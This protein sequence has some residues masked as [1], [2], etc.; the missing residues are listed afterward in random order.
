[1]RALPRLTGHFLVLTGTFAVAVPP[2]QAALSTAIQ[3]RAVL[4]GAKPYDP[5]ATQSFTLGLSDPNRVYNIPKVLRPAYLG[6]NTDPTFGTPITRVT[7]NA[8]MGIG[9][10]S[11]SWGMDARHVYSKQEPWNSD[12][13]LFSVENR[14]GGSPS[15][16]L[17]DGKTF[18]PVA[19]P[20]G[21]YD[22]Y[23]YR[24]HP[25]RSHPHEQINVNSAGD[26]LMWF[27]VTTCTKTRSWKLPITVDYGIGSGE[28]NASNDGRY[29]VL[30][31][32]TQ[33]FV[34]DMDPQPPFAPYP[35][36]R[37]G[38]VYTI[39]ACDLDSS[40]PSRCV[41]NNISISPLGHYVDVNY[42]G[43]T[44]IT[45][46]AHRIFDVN[47]FTLAIMGPHTMDPTALRC[48][49]DF[50]GRTD[51][52]IF[53]TKH[54]D[55]TVDPFDSN[56]EVMIGGRSCSESNIGHVVKIRLRDGKVTPLTNPD[57]EAYVTHVSTRNL[58]RPGWA[59]VG[60]EPEA[61]MRF[62]DE[63]VA[64]KLDGSG[65]VQ[66]LA[67]KHTLSSGCYRCEAHAVPSPDGKRVVF[68]SNWAE[69]CVKC[70][71]TSDIKDFLLTLPQAP[72]TDT[73][74]VA[75]P[76]Q[77]PVEFALHSAWPNPATTHM[78]ISYSLGE[79]GGGHLEIM[80]VRGRAVWSHELDGESPG[81]HSFDLER[82]RHWAAGVYWLRLTQSGHSVQQK[83]T[84][85]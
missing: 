60:F 62:A 56:Q 10:V 14:D 26:E 63:I 81:P 38:P 46:D 41:V 6:L 1:M 48:G 30:G 54:A 67:H 53:P 40:D 85:L 20:C 43:L 42:D 31:N 49:S 21:N 28:G 32:Q 34:V 11:G 47:P 23:D 65:D 25:S 5:V 58:E 27:D 39:P 45:E 59:Y 50:A 51:G 3:P 24:W 2:G 55:M 71:K 17:L 33:M 4:I 35:H 36:Q 69:S 16:L 57:N 76:V 78:A 66:R 84:L 80:D 79:G 82:D 13:T 37:I 64:V 22:F 68:A 74:T 83:V 8:G 29:V 77:A 15:V 52:W 75:A 72:D 73:P 7:N 12:M 18:T 9:T 70:G 44:G 19:Q 61:G